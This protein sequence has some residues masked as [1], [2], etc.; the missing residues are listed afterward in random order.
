MHKG[1]MNNLS[2]PNKCMNYKVNFM[3]NETNEHLWLV[4]KRYGLDDGKDFFFLSPLD[5]MKCE[6]MT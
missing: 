5:K 2:D 6:S 4:P 1:G 3:K